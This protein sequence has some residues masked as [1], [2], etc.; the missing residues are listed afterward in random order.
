MTTVAT[1]TPGA[2]RDV[3]AEV[4]AALACGGGPAGVRRFLLERA[5]QL[6]A[7]ALD[8]LLEPGLRGADV[9]CRLLR[10]KIRPHHR[11]SAWYEL[12][13]PGDGPR[14]AAVTWSAADLPAP[15]EPRLEAEAVARGTAGPF[16][17]LGA[18]CGDGRM[19][20]LV[21]P[22]DPAFP[23]LVRLHDRDHLASALRRAGVAA[24]AEPTLTAVRYRPGQRHVLRLG[25]GPSGAA[26]AKVYRDGAGGRSLPRARR[27]AAALAGADVR[28]AV[29]PL[30]GYLTAEHT[31]LWREVPGRPLSAL[32]AASS[33]DAGTAVR[34][35]GAALRALHDQPAPAAPH[36]PADEPATVARAAVHVGV[37]HPT[38]GRR[39]ARQLEQVGALLER[40]P[41]EAPRLVH[42]DAK[43]DNLLVDGDRL[44]LVD[45]DRAGP[46]D[47]AAD[48]GKLR[49]DLRWWGAPRL[50]AE[51]GEGYG[52]ASAARAARAHAYDVLFGL[53]A[54][55]RRL[56]PVEETW[57][58]RVD[59]ALDEA[60]VLL[61][62]GPW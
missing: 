7:D 37:L 16:R 19:Q 1:A 8:D 45:L 26:Y 10:T 4:S 51:L 60:D 40:L 17:R 52:A 12:L 23:Q 36:A 29:A 42:G 3:R 38:A 27:A 6:L 14:S 41:A 48:L 57:A 50:R 44:V 39:L 9:P 61:R 31:V 21:A 56:S 2:D 59:A 55:A 35:A 20:V 53:K 24:P 32:V 54:L 28:C 33:P 43:G 11:V 22:Y 5:P 25:G 46:G 13:A 18:V 49:A 30:L 58:D 15:Y 62:E 34:T 47:P